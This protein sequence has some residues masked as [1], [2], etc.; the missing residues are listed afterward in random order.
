MPTW[1]NK[2]QFPHMTLALLA[3]VALVLIAYQSLGPGTAS[4]GLPPLP[5]DAPSLVEIFAS[6]ANRDEALHDAALFAAFCTAFS[7]AIE[8]DGKQDRPIIET[9]NQ[10]DE[11]RIIGRWR[12]MDGVPLSK[13]YPKLGE[14]VA[15]YITKTAG[16][17]PDTVTADGRKNWV[18][19]YR[20]LGLAAE[21]A[22]AKL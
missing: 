18:E 6:N 3:A 19:A 16:T 22:K 20:V 8:R 2:P 13:T 17:N 5:A 10:L 21:H 7:K 11:K 1:N 14:V 4:S 9:G 15:E 12:V